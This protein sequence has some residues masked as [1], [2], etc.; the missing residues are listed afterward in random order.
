MFSIVLQITLPAELFRFYLLGLNSTSPR[1]MFV[2]NKWNF[3]C[4]K[5]SEFLP[6]FKN[7]F[8]ARNR[9]IFSHCTFKHNGF[10]ISEYL[11]MHFPLSV[12]LSLDFPSVSPSCR[13]SASQRNF[14][15]R[16]FSYIVVVVSCPA[17]MPASLA[18]PFR[19]PFDI[20]Y[21]CFNQRLVEEIHNYGTGKWVV[22]WLL[23]SFIGW[24][25]MTLLNAQLQAV[26]DGDGW[27]YHCRLV[28]ILITI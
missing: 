25:T 17:C 27:Y 1:C 9:N 4:M 20:A 21:H 2:S 7:K 23:A 5:F 13:F 11:W 22:G 3:L 28:I 15:R 16:D 24:M 10:S 18:L 8:G 12:S 26:E 6:D 14:S 19:F